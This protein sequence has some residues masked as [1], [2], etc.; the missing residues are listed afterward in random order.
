MCKPLSHDSS[1]PDG[2][3]AAAGSG[4]AAAGTCGNRLVTELVTLRLFAGWPETSPAR[5]VAAASTTINDAAAKVFHTFPAPPNVSRHQPS[6][7]IASSFDPTDLCPSSP[8]RRVF[9]SPE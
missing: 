9:L 8:D 1:P 7:P 3:G 5:L 4:G 6:N 2:G